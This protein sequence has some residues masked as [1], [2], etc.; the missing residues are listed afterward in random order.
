M[1][2]FSVSTDTSLQAILSSMSD[3]PNYQR[4]LQLA[5]IATA[6]DLQFEA[7]PYPGPANSPVEW[8]SDKQRRYYFALR[9]AQGLPPNYTRQSDGMSERLMESWAV[10]PYETTGALLKNS[11]TYAP[12]VIGESQQIQHELTGWRKLSDVAE[13]FFNSGRAAAVFEKTFMQVI[14]AERKE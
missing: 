4:A 7:R 13:D 2:T 1:M 8:A 6:K 5:S 9:R 10:E 3:S 11:A 14:S 12:Y